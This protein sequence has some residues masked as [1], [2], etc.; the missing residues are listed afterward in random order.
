[1][2]YPGVQLCAPPRVWEEAPEPWWDLGEPCNDSCS[3]LLRATSLLYTVGTADS[4]PSA[5]L[6]GNLPSPKP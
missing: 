6:Q 5:N 3:L 4:Q 2:H 1:M